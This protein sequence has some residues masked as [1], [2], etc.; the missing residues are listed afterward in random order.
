MSLILITETG[1]NEVGF[2]HWPDCAESWFS[3]ISEHQ[4][5]WGFVKQGLG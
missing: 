5:P 4:S 1:P 2:L 3:D